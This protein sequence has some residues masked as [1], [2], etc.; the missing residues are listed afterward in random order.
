MYTSTQTELHH[1]HCME[2]FITFVAKKKTKSCWVHI[3][4]QVTMGYQWLLASNQETWLNQQLSMLSLF[5]VLDPSQKWYFQFKYTFR[6]CWTKDASSLD[7]HISEMTSVPVD[8]S[9]VLF[10]FLL[11]HVLVFYIICPGHPPDLNWHR[12]PQSEWPTPQP[13]H[14]VQLSQRCPGYQRGRLL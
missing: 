12:W 11:L 2:H 5:S 7:S 1:V 3:D 4:Y 13:A 6:Q 8:W 14:R 9:Q 10:W